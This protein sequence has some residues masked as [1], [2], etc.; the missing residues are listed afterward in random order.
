MKYRRPGSA[1]GSSSK[2]RLRKLITHT[3]PGNEAGVGPTGTSIELASEMLD[4]T[5][6]R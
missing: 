1:V 3:V 4:C 6:E 2:S 5:G